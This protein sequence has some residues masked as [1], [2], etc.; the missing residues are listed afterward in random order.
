[1]GQPQD[2]AKGILDPKEKVVVHT[3]KKGESICGKITRKVDYMTAALL[4]QEYKPLLNFMSYH[5][6]PLIFGDIEEDKVCITC[7]PKDNEIIREYFPDLSE[8]KYQ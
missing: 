6:E 7:I 8:I 5:E 2:R 3:L 4:R 1:M